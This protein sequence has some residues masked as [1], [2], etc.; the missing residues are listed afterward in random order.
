M[1][2]NKPIKITFSEPVKFANKWIELKS[3]RGILTPLKKTIAGN[4]LT[5]TPT[6]LLRKGTTY[7]VLLHTNSIS[8]LNGNIIFYNMFR[9]TTIIKIDIINKATGGDITKN[10]LLT[11]YIPKTVLTEQIFSKSRIGTPMITFGDVNGP[12]ILIVA[13]VHGNELPAPA[14]TMKLINYLNGKSIR[15]TIYIIPFAI[16]YCTAHTQRY[17]KNQNPNRIANIPG[18]PTNIIVDLAKKL[19]I[20]AL[21]DFHSS[22]P[23]GVP[24]RDSALCTKI[25]TF[26]S[27]KIAAYISKKSGSTLIANKTAGDKYHGALED[28]NNLRGIPSVTCEVLAPH[29]TLNLNRIN[30]SFNQMIALLKYNKVL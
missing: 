5:L 15:G 8:D 11:S 29:G 7:T 21:G 6:K 4:T 26:K 3:G 17:W 30:K 23:G 9:F 2:I 13:G 19:K 24:G 27:Y 22:I 16:P 1:P 10:Y 14:A 20:N 12:K 18:S 28:V 25:P